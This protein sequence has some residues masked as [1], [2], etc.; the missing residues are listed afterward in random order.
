MK[1]TP[2]LSGDQKPVRVGVYERSITALGKSYSFW[3]GEFWCY[4]SSEIDEAEM[5]GGKRLKSKYQ[6]ASWRGVMK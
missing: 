5:H 1:L 4:F 3:N 6:Q 2:W